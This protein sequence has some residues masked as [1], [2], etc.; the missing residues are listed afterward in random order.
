MKI[1][2]LTNPDATNT[3]DMFSLPEK[4][5]DELMELVVEWKQTYENFNQILLAAEQAYDQGQLNGQEFMFCFYAIG[6]HHGREASMKAAELKQQ[7]MEKLKALFGKSDKD[8]DD[9]IEDTYN[10]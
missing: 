10:W 6:I 4:R 9:R 2:F 1:E 3:C 5:I 7:A 8:P